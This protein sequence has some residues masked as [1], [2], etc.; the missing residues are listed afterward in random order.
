MRQHYLWNM[1]DRYEIKGRIGQG[2]L[3]S[4]YRGFDNRMNREVAIKRISH[5]SEDADMRDESTKQLIRE[6]GA[7]ASL[8]HPHIVTI[9]DVGEDEE[10][11]YVIME[12]L[13]GKPL[14]ELI[15]RAPLTWSDFHELA[16]QTQ[17]A[18][19]AAQD[20][21]IIHSDLKPSNLM[22]SW[23]PS[24]KFQ[25]KIVDFGLASINQSQSAEE[26]EEME[27]VF[28]SI[29]FMPPEQFERKPLDVR[30]DVYSM[31]CVYYQA[32]AGKY[33]YNGAT[34]NE[35][36]DA[37]LRHTVQDLKEL[38][39]DLPPWVS[40]WIMWQINRNPEDRPKDSREC[41]GVFLQNDKAPVVVKRKPPMAIPGST[42]PVPSTTRVPTATQPLK[43]Q[44]GMQTTQPGKPKTAVVVPDSAPIGGPAASTATAPQ[45]LAPPEG[46]KPSIYTPI[47]P[48][49]TT[50]VEA[51]PTIIIKQ[52]KKPMS[53]A[54]KI[55]LSAGL[56]AAVAF[57]ALFISSEMKKKQQAEELNSLITMAENPATDDVPVTKAQLDKILAF[58]GNPQSPLREVERYFRVLQLAK[59]PDGTDTDAR[60]VAEATRADFPEYQKK[61]ILG[62]VIRLRKNPAVVP[63]I[64]EYV[65]T[66]SDPKIAGIAIDGIRGYAPEETLGDFLNLLSTSSS[67]DIQI[68]S[69]N[70]VADI[71]GRSKDKKAVMA[72][73]VTAYKAATSQQNKLI[74]QQI[75]R[76]IGGEE[77][78]E[79]LR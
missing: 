26:L 18:L 22:L 52:E 71:Y 64:L 53:T 42:K 69:R 28:G 13:T 70:A 61:E 55:A 32:L 6:A 62:N 19:I 59:G 30:S 1:E 68:G 5:T 75:I 38:R 11:P 27:A 8:Q 36:M 37:H 48:T 23:L 40:E 67:N 35:V 77:A 51:A 16:L 57:A 4:V 65:K 66:A 21:S 46:S 12:L 76:Q 41:L 78:V 50:I 10:G 24:G 29:F 7:L 73:I 15:E 49:A 34:G 63:K 9:Y 39:P 56:L 72:K 43:T 44:T 60:I 54:A 74:L 79:N 31:G 47:D 25:V 33:P 17:E 45:P 58:V 20:L 14:D 3:G 2:G